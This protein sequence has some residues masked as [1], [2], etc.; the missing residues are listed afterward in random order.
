MAGPT[1][2]ARALIAAVRRGLADRADPARAPQMQAYMK[3]TMPYRGVPSPGVRALCREVFPAHPLPDRPAWE[4]AVRGLWDDAAYREERY[5]GIALTGDRAYA[6]Y[7]DP[8]A[9]ALYE[10]LVVSGAWWDFVDE[11]AIRRV[12]PIL[13]AH[14]AEVTPVLRAWARDD[15]LWRR[16]TAI[17]AQIKAKHA[18]DLALLD[19]CVRA[20]L[21]HRDFFVRKGIGWALR[22]YAKTDPAWARAY[23]ER[24]RDAMAPLSVRE[25]TKHLGG[26]SP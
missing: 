24:H 21:D 17:I 11:V 10:H 4:S 26:V 6:G 5:A 9:M 2:P 16:R 20:N 22:E 15:D 14:P 12:G 25:A 13:L 18:T 8:D 23:V 7:Q 19:H 3:S 1:T